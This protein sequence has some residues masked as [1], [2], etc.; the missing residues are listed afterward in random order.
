[1]P[2]LLSPGCGGRPE[3]ASSGAPG[4]LVPKGPILDM[5][6]R[7]IIL[8]L[9]LATLPAQ[10][11]SSLLMLD[12][13]GREISSLPRIITTCGIPGLN[14]GARDWERSPVLGHTFA[15]YSE[16]TTLADGVDDTS[17]T[18]RALLPIA[19]QKTREKLRDFQGMARAIN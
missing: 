18:I 1:M 6:A 15:E 2:S 4:P 19:A 10:F 5:R 8:L 12:L 14:L 17:V 7:S 11:A 3:T 9:I 16:P 13:D